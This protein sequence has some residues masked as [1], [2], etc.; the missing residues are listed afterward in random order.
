MG[1]FKDLLAWQKSLTLAKK[2]Y[3]VTG[4]FPTEERFGLVNQMRRCAVSIPSNI[5][6]GYGRGSDKELL[7]FLYV[8]LGSSNELETQLILSLELSFMKEED[9]RML[10]GLNTEVNK[11]ILSLIYRRKN[12]LDKNS[13]T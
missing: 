8:A 5:A 9:S 3:Q 7:R 4:N 10:Q 13:R 11:M 1:T 12:G 2:V 6:E